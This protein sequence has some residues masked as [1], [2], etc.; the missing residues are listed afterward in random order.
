MS[1]KREIKSFWWSPAHPDKKWFGTLTLG[2]DESPEL[3]LI[4]ERQNPAD[5][6]VMMGSVIHGRDEHGKPITLLFAG[7]SGD[8]FSNAVVKRKFSAGYAM[9]GIELSDA[10][11]FV[12]N[13]LRFQIQHLYGWLG[14]SGFKR[15]TEEKHREFIVSFEQQPDEWFSIL[16]D[17]ELAIHNTFETKGGFQ[18]RGISEDAA[19]TFRTK[20]GFSLKRCSDL[21]SAMR[22]LLHFAVMKRVYPVWITA[23]KNGHGSEV[24]GQ[25]FDDD[26]DIQSS[27]L[28]EPKSE[29]PIPHYWIFRFDD[30]RQ[31]FGGFIREWLEYVQKFAEP[32]NCYSSTIYH[33]LTAELSHLSLTQA[34]EAYHGIRFSSHHKHEF[35]GKIEELSN[36]HAISLKGLVDDIPDFSERVLCTRNH[37][38]HHN[39]KWLATGKVAQKAE[40]TRLNEKLR[41]LFQMCIL[42]DLKIPIDRFSR[43]RR[44]LAIEIIDYT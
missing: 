16:P 41:L 11:S 33:P 40:L 44:Q 29:I 18:E 30:I 42:S 12:A 20:E 26:I 27:I 2:P 15:N 37:Y 13:S 10:D 43:L 23:Y 7:S 6:A 36:L 22:T 39:P 32:L 25:W 19:L 24:D 8:H 28:R 34:L 1:A 31:D 17:L 14:R 9:I 21:I 35:K 4:S 38:T 5:R 3:E